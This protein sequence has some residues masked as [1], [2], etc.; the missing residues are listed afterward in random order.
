MNFIALRVP[1]SGTK[2][3]CQLESV[4]HIISM[5]NKLLHENSFFTNTSARDRGYFIIAPDWVSERKGV[6]STHYQWPA[7]I[8]TFHMLPTDRDEVSQQLNRDTA[9]DDGYR[10]AWKQDLDGDK[11]NPKI[12]GASVT[13]FH[14]TL[15]WVNENF[16]VLGDLLGPI[17]PEISI[18]FKNRRQYLIIQ[19][20][21]FTQL[22]FNKSTWHWMIARTKCGH[23]FAFCQV[24]K[25]EIWAWATTVFTV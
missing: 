9:L 1:Q 20:F 7:V 2:T 4:S 24:W 3:W 23:K 19:V 13:N 14:L 18:F 22:S 10:H 6:M 5:M 25:V 15:A 8:S 21:T 16:P 12:S 17:E 11:N